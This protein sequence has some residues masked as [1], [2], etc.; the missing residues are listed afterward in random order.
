MEIKIVEA[1][2]V[3]GTTKNV[4]MDVTNGLTQLKKEVGEVKK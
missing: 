1:K 4:V 2:K 3:I